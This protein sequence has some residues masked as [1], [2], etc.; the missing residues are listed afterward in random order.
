MNASDQSR[1][2]QPGG[3][4]GIKETLRAPLLAEPPLVVAVEN[5]HHSVIGRD[6]PVS[7]VVPLGELGAFAGK[8]KVPARGIDWRNHPRT[9][10]GVTR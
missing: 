5:R 3:F 9:L 1:A 4:L 2:G 6:L 7:P 8:V 10:S